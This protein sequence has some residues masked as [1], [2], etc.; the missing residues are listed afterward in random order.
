MREI[1]FRAWDTISKRMIG[2]HDR[3]F[4][5]TTIYNNSAMLCEMPLRYAN[6]DS[7]F[8]KYMQYTGLHDRN[9]KEI[10]EGDIL[11]RPEYAEGQSD[12][13]VGFDKGYFTLQH[14]KSAYNQ[15]G[16][17]N[18]AHTTEVIGNIHA[19]PE[20]LAIKEMAE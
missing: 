3:A 18:I 10:Y 9:G 1:K 14:T 15:L 7:C 19:S 20:L 12:Y 11:R 4:E 13:V 16:I 8:F 6:S 5:H 17:W 2:W